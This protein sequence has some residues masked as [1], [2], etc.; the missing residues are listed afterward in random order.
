MQIKKV[1]GACCDKH[2]E[3]KSEVDEKLSIEQWAEKIR[4]LVSN[5]MQDFR[6]FDEWKIDLKIQLIFCHQKIVMKSNWYILRW[7]S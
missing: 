4:P 5:M 1:A 7:I 3:Y 2:I 6:I